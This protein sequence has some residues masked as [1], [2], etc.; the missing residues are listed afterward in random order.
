MSDRDVDLLFMILR[1]ENET[2]FV[3]VSWRH[4]VTGCSSRNWFY[5]RIKMIKGVRRSDLAYH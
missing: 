4:A 3:H 5:Y 1:H 2:N